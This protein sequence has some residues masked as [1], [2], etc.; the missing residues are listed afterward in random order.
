MYEV[1]F[2]EQAMAELNSQPVEKQLTL[3]E[4]ISR[5]RSEQLANPREPLSRVHREGID[6]Y[7]LKADDFRFYFVVHA[8]QLFCHY[9]LHRNTLADFIF[10]NKL[11]ITED[12]INE[13][14][15]SFWKYL[16]SLTKK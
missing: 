1:T 14:S 12:Q 4:Q 16:E 15:Q 5:I 8:N 6:F 10:R 13:Q 7:R 2:S 3:V 11:K 9:I